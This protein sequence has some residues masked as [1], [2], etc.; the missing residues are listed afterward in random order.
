MKIHDIDMWINMDGMAVDCIVC[1]QSV[2]IAEVNKSLGI[3]NQVRVFLV[4]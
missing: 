3:L 4:A 1:G 2:A